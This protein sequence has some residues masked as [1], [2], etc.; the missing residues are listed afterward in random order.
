MSRPATDAEGNPIICREAEAQRDALI[1]KLA[2]LPPVATALDQIVQ[3]FRHEAVAEVTGRSRRV[4]R[5]FDAKG[6]RLALRSRPADAVNL[7][8]A[9]RS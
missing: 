1:E 6:E 8:K 9:G 5:I 7:T 2:A 4:L 3:R